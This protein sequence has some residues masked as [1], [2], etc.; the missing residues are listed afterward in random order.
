[1][2]TFESQSKNKDPEKNSKLRI[3]LWSCEKAIEQWK[4]THPDSETITIKEFEG[5]IDDIVDICTNR[6]RF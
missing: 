3:Y 6:G 2:R 1:M 5:V 4:T